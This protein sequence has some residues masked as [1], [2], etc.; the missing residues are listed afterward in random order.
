MP[1][2]KRALRSEYGKAYMIDIDGVVCEHVPNEFPELMKTASEMP[3]A[4]DWINARYDE[5]NYV[6]FFTAR[7][8][9]HRKITEKWLKD[10][11][12]KFHQIVF[13]KPRGGN[14]HYIDRAHVQATTFKG[15]FSP[16]VAETHGIEVF[17]E[18]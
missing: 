17:D 2:S 4:R 13:G 7:L 16:M 14:Y 6:C 15:R 9:K 10:H 12:F 1:R 5:G 11:G 18:D 3:G 8:E